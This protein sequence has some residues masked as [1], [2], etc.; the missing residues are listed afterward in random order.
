MMAQ[1]GVERQDGRH[2][3]VCR[4][5]PTDGIP[6]VRAPPAAETL[7]LTGPGRMSSRARHREDADIVAGF[8]LAV[9]TAM[10]GRPAPAG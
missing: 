1:S 6:P 3:P 4:A 2:L 9:F 8:A 7:A 10:D 5:A